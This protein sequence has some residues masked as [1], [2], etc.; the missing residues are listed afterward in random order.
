[1]SRV[2]RALA[3]SITPPK[4]QHFILGM[5]KIPKALPLMSLISPLR[6]DFSIFILITSYV[7][8]ILQLPKVFVALF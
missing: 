3:F 8:E 6:T 1:M 4:T 2:G 7:R 5:K